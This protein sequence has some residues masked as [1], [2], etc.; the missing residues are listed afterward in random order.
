MTNI[1]DVWA[2]SEHGVWGTLSDKP[3]FGTLGC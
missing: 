3:K 1:Y 2:M